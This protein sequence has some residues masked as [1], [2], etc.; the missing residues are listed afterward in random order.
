MYVKHNGD[1]YPCCQSYML[2]G[3]PVG[4]VSSQPLEEI[5]NSA[6]MR[7]MRRLHITGRAGEIDICSRCLTTIPHP[8]LVAGSLVLHGKWVRRALPWI[9]RMSYVRKLPKRFL[10]PP[11]KDVAVGTTDLVQIG[12]PG[13]AGKPTPD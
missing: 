4:H 13:Q 8:I 9:E 5:W 6:E 12:K 2:D 10:T 3:A 1:V 7:R 11:R